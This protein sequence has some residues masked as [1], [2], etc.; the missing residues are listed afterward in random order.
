[1]LGFVKVSNQY[2]TYKNA[3]EWINGIDALV[4]ACFRDYFQIHKI[5]YMNT[6]QA[7]KHI[8]F[9]ETPHRVLDLGGSGLFTG[10]AREEFG[11]T[12]L[13]VTY[14]EHKDRREGLHDDKNIML[15]L[16][17]TNTGHASIQWDFDRYCQN[18]DNIKFD[19][20]YALEV[21]EHIATDP[22]NF[23]REIH[24]LMSDDGYLILTTPNIC[25]LSAIDRIVK[26]INPI[27][28]PFFKK[29]RTSDRHNIEYTVNDL[30]SLLHQ[31]GFEVVKIYTVDSWSFPS[32]E[33]LNFC[34]HANISLED[35]GDNIIAICRRGSN[36]QIEFPHGI[37]D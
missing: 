6:Y 20:V 37:Y 5:R 11:A 8:E 29:D 4:P 18:T 13:Y 17:R 28:Y 15:P 30:N 19:L 21:I 32:L 34:R 12:E 36:P 35:R 2:F 22:A 27:S 16:D 23:L 7:L 31:S 10:L 14:F 26:S 25:S 3:C 24:K 33:L 1:M 9:S